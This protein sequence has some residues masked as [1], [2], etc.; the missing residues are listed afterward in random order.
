MES[1][2]HLA[3]QLLWMRFFSFL[4]LFLKSPPFPSYLR[5]ARL[6]FVY[7]HSR[8]HTCMRSF[9]PLWIHS[10]STFQE[11]FKSFDKF[12]E[13]F[14][15]YQHYEEALTTKLYGISRHF[16]FLVSHLIQTR[17]FPIQLIHESVTLTQLKILL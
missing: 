9:T 17:T 1:W 2:R 14:L 3:I 13:N 7:H 16:S 10:L 15:F 11:F 5:T 12:M 8:V 4:W 6:M